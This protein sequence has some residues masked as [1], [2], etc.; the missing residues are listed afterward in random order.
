MTTPPSYKKVNPADSPILML[1]VRSDTMPL[2]MVDD[3]ADLFLAQQISQVPGVAQ[4]SIF[5]DQHAGDPHPGRSGQARRQR[6]HAGGD[7]Q[8]RSSPP[9][10]TPPRAR[11]T[12][13]SSASRSPPT[14][15]SPRPSSSTTSSSPIATARRSACATSARR[16]PRQVDRNVAAYQNNQPG[17]ILAVFKQPGAN[18]IETVDQIK[19]QLPQLTARIPPAIEVEDHPRPHHDHPRLGRATC[20]FTLGAHHRPGGAGDPA[21][22][23]QFL[24]H[25]DPEH[26]RAAGAARVVRGDV[27]AQLQPRQPLA[28][29]ADHRRRLRGRRR[30]RRGREH[31]PPHRGREPAV[32]GRDQGLARDRLHRAVD[33]RLAGRGVHS[34]AADGRHHRPPVPRIRA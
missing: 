6:R 13:T 17:V 14:T 31:L 28:D 26:H 29:G 23:A 11:S 25:A 19:A 4:V 22:P 34:A 27:S 21:V 15:R 2:T 32:R 9:P 33:Q 10:P 1:S 20:E 3:Y 8:R 16:C 7:P 18:V 5:G 24:G 12:P 30:H